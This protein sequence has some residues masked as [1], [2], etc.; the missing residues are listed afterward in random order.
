MKYRL[1]RCYSPQGGGGSTVTWDDI[2]PANPDDTWTGRNL[3]IEIKT[4]NGVTMTKT[5]A[6]K[7]IKGIEEGFVPILVQDDTVHG[8]RTYSFMNWIADELTLVSTSS[9]LNLH[10]DYR[11]LEKPFTTLNSTK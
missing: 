9:S 1:L 2:K 8:A 11:H 7:I 3:Y 6:G 10:A 5:S 4:V